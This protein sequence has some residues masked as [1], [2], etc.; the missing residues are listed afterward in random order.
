M[1]LILGEILVTQLVVGLLDKILVL[2][3]E[4]LVTTTPLDW[5]LVVWRRMNH[6]VTVLA[7]I[8]RILTEILTVL[9]EI[10]EILGHNFNLIISGQL[11]GGTGSPLPAPP[12][13][14]RGVGVC[15]CHKV[16]VQ[17]N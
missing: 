14:K 12:T 9:V 6:L 1:Q 3:I 13:I 11:G 16:K 5:I 7:E 17:L 15:Q 10:L 2:L 4:I 8:L